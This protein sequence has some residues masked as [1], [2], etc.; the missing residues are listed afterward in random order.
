M[1]RVRR[2]P[3][4]VRYVILLIAVW[5]AVVAVAGTALLRAREHGQ[6]NEQREFQ[7]RTRVAARFVG[8]YATRLPT[9][10]ERW[11]GFALSGERA[12][13]DA[14]RAPCTGLGFSAC[15][16]FDAAGVLLMNS[17]HQPDLIGRSFADLPQVANALRTGRP[18]IGPVGISPALRVPVVPFGLPY[19]TAYGTRVFT[20]VFKI[21][22]SALLNDAKLSLEMPSVATYII[23]S[24]GN[25]AATTTGTLPGVVTA[26]TSYDRSLAA[27]LTRASNGFAGGRYFVASGVP[28]TPWTLISTVPRGTLYQSLGSFT[29]SSLW[30]LAAVTV[31]GLVASIALTRALHHTDRVRAELESARDRNDQRQRLAR[32]ANDTIVQ[33]LVAA[34]AAYDLDRPEQARELLR[35]SSRQ[36]RDWVGELV[37]DAGGLRP[38]TAR[39]DAVTAGGERP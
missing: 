6:G 19:G 15:G 11:A 14:L 24:T 34:E 4:W 1:T 37:I 28:G 2:T 9:R 23:D 33:N 13:V 18:Y 32:E 31:I 26:L 7:D 21:Q 36:A 35:I 17:P 30:T 12:S 39:R 20:G 25:V 22:D 16:L 38:G 3:V 27:G 29:A 5:L 10:M 8:S